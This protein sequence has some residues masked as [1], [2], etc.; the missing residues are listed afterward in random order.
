MVCVGVD[1]WVWQYAH[2]QLQTTVSLISF[3]YT[4]VLYIVSMRETLRLE[5][6]GHM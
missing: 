4:L 5:D 1:G 2:I 6:N 3:S